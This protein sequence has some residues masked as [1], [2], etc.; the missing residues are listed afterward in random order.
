MSRLFSPVDS[1]N[2]LV[3]N[4]LPTGRAVRVE[5]AVRFNGIT[6]MLGANKKLYCPSLKNGAYVLGEWPWQSGFLR[7]CVHL[8]VITAS[9]MKR[10]MDAA[11]AKAFKSDVDY[12]KTRLKHYAEKCGVKL[13]N[14]QLAKIRDSQ[15]R[16]A[17][18]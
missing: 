14:R 12:N 9:D 2:N 13:T 8:G 17:M 6:V 3:V 18:A 16:K 10:H 15:R 5:K 7:A 11:R 4:Q 1:I